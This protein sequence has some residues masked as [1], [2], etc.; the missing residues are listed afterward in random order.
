MACVVLRAGAAL[1]PDGLKDYCRERLTAYKV[2]RTFYHF[3]ELATDQIGK[4]RRREVQ[5]D[6]L[7]MLGLVP[8]EKDDATDAEEADGSDDSDNS[9]KAKP[10]D[11]QP[12]HQESDIAGVEVDDLDDAQPDEDAV[13]EAEDSTDEA[14]KK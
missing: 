13:A 14:D 10:L 11:E 7:D 3:E 1:D 5:A 12:D 4:L 2:P 6:L 9:G 8:K